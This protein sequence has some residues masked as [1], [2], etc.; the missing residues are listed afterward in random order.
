MFAHFFQRDFRDHFC[1][2]LDPS[3]QTGPTKTYFG[4]NAFSQISIARSA[5]SYEPPTQDVDGFLSPWNDHMPLEKRFAHWD[6]CDAHR[7]IVYVNQNSIQFLSIRIHV[8][9]V[10]F[11]FSNGAE[12]GQTLF[13]VAATRGR[14]LNNLHL[15]QPPYP[16]FL[17][18]GY[19]LHCKR[20]KLYL[21]FRNLI[22]KN[23]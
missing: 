8:G 23:V 7:F 5:F 14:R 21:S 17:G 10:H 9:M 1:N 22:W 15:P 3:F 19:T 20:T 6:I 18:Q 2:I 16:R 13:V 4:N 11:N 12:L